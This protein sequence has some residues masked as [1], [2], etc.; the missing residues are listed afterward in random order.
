MLTLERMPAAVQ[1]DATRTSP[2]PPRSDVGAAPPLARKPE[3][4]AAP[5]PAMAPTAPIDDPL[6]DATAL[7]WLPLAVP[8]LGLAILCSMGIVW[9]VI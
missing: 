4:V 3:F 7:R 6:L 1:A 5:V 2:S 9:F 8:L